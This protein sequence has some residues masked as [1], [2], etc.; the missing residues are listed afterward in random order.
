MLV[1]EINSFFP[2][3][4]ETV[5]RI[6]EEAFGQT[7]TPWHV[8]DVARFGRIFGIWLDDVLLGTT[9]FIKDW[10]NTGTAYLVGMAIKTSLQNKGYGTILLKESLDNLKEDNIKAVLLH[11]DPN[12]PR[13][14]HM[15]LRKFRF[16]EVEYRKNEYGLGEDRILMKL[17][18]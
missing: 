7:L 2:N 17:L 8:E 9:Q 10:D 3:L 18:L 14:I 13:A 1:K 5:I 6:E 4:L 12:N 11:V 15:Y 16:A